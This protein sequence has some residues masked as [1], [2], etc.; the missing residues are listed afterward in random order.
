MKNS[1]LKIK[2]KK[3]RDRANQLQCDILALSNEVMELHK[4]DTK[5]TDLLQAYIAIRVADMPAIC[6]L[7]DLWTTL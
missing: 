6:R 4:G 2:T 5:E 1:E 7:H 3:L